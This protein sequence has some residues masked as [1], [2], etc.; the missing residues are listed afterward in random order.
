MAEV[1]GVVSSGIAVVG[2]AGQ[3]AKQAIA[4]KQLWDEVKGVPEGIQAL[5][6]QLELL[7]PVLADMEVSFLE[8]P[9]IYNNHATARQSIAY[10]TKAI[11]DLSVLT[12][13]LSQDINSAKWLKKSKSRIRIVLKKDQINAY[14][15]R[16]QNALQLLGL[17]QQIYLAYVTEV[18]LLIHNVTDPRLTAL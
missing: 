8:S 10:C 1:L 17:S 2:L 7:N 6:A 18:R 13:D 15:E 5:V 4:L 16:L 14:R 3:V 11:E 12:T 9:E